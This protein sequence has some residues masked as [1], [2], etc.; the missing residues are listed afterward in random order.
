MS[1][2]QQPNL[3]QQLDGDAKH[4]FSNPK[5]VRDSI[6]AGVEEDSEAPYPASGPNLAQKILAIQSAVGVVKKRGKFDAAMGNSNFLRIEDAV[7]AV[8]KLMVEQGL[9]LTGTLAKRPDNTLYYD[10]TPHLKTLKDGE[11]RSGYIASVIFDWTLEDVVSGESRTWQIPG[12]GYDSTDKGTPKAQTSSRKYAI[13]EIA[14][15]AVGNDIEGDAATF[16][17]GKE[18]ASKVAASKIADAAGR[19]NKTALDTYSQIEPEKKLVIARPE[20]FNGHYVIATGF[21]AAPPLDQFF[22]DT[23][24]KR[25]NSP[26]TGKAGWKVPAEYEKGLIALC[27]KL[28]IEVDG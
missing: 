12:E 20:E 26:R 23:G 11:S 8:S 9:I 19:G 1:D 24:S 5:G 16:V 2:P 18:R 4:R 27:E 14:N 15:L 21:I 10:R 3:L 7:L 28:K 22:E 6:K 25:L 13:I 17:D